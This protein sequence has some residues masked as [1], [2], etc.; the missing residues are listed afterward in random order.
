MSSKPKKSYM[1][2]DNVQYIPYDMQP[3]MLCFILVIKKVFLWISS[4]EEMFITDT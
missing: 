2:A 3:G 4:I 1:I